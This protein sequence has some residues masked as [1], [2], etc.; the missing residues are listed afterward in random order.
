M[1][2]SKVV[3]THGGFTARMALGQVSGLM[4]FEGP[5][6]T[7]SPVC[8]WLT[9]N[10]RSRFDALQI[11]QCQDSCT[12]RIIGVKM[13]FLWLINEGLLIILTTY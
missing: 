7:G 11:V 5:S 12:V 2:G 13:A 1:F 4:S 8:A 3:S 9:A 10:A 6:R